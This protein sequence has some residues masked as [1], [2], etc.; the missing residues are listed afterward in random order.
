MTTRP[1]EPI[2]DALDRADAGLLARRLDAR[3]CP[4]ELLARLVR[5]PAPR[6]RH[7]GLTLLTERTDTP[8]AGD[9]SAGGYAGVGGDGEGRAGHP[10][11]LD[12]LLPASPGESPEESLL[13][14]RLHARLVTQAPR[15]RLPDWRAAALPAR[16]RIAWL[17][18]ELLDDPAVLR[19]E[20][21]GELLYRAVRESA[22]ADAR[23]PDLLVAE[24][25][26]GG[27][28]V[29]RAEA[30]RLARDGLHAGLLAPAFVRGRLVR[31]LDAPEHD[32]VTG[33]LRELAEPWAVVTP[34]DASLLS[35]PADARGGRCADG[36]GARGGSRCAE[37]G[38]PASSEALAA[39]AL[40]AG[41]RH[42]HHVVL[43]T[44]AEDPSE[45]PALRRQ[46]VELLGDQA[47]RTDIGRLV[48]LAATDPLLL[49]GPVL[50]C[51]RGLH[52]RGHFPAEPDTGPLLALALA[53]RTVPA[54]DIA[55][56]LYT[57]RR[58]LFDALVDA[59]SSAPDW[60][61]R[62]ELLVALA[63]QGAADVPIG[64]AV[65]RLLPAARA[66]RPFLDAI[67]V[68]RPQGAEEAVLALLPVAPSAALDALEAIGGD[69][70]R[71]TLARGLG[72]GGP[73]DG[74]PMA[75]DRAP[76]LP[77]APGLRPVRD[78][79]AALLWH[80][81]HEPA[82]RRDL[83]ARLDPQALPPDIEADLGA[84]DERE[85]AVLR[86][87]VDV[88]DP[89]AA[90]SRIA[91]YADAGTLPLVADLLLRIVRDLAAPRDPAHVPDRPRAD[92]LHPG[93]E[94]AEP[95]R[96][97]GEPEL[98][99]EAL[100]AVRALGRRL[101]G[102]RWIRPVCLLDA[103]DDTGAGH[104]FLTATVLG[105]LERPGLTGGERALLLKAL[106]Q[107][108]ATAS[109]R[110]RVH[111]MLRTRDP[112]VRK[113]VI[114]LLAHDSSGQDARAL[115]ATLVPLT[116]D[117]DIRTVRAALLALGTARAR[118]A[119]EAVAGCLHHPNMNIRKT[120]AATL[121]HTGAPASVPHLLR[122]LGRDDNP[123]LRSALTRALRAVVG[124]AYAATLLAAAEAA[125]DERTR[126]LLLCAL[127]GEV[128]ARAVLAL[129]VGDSPVVP[130]LLTLVADGA[131]RLAAGSV[132]DLAEPL[133][134][135]GVPTPPGVPGGPPGAADPEVAALLRTGWDPALALRIARRPVPP[136]VGIARELP[137]VRVLLGD[138]LGLAD[139]AGEAGIRGRLVRCGLRLC[140]G[141]WSADEVAVFARYAGTVTDA[142]DAA[143]GEEAGRA[144]QAGW[145]E[146]LIEVLHA[147]APHL[148]AVQR[149][150]VVEGLRR[151][152]PD[153][154][155]SPLRTGAAA[156]AFALLRRSGAVLVRADL[157][158]ALAAAHLGADPWRAGPA[159][160]REAFGVP[161]ERAAS[162]EPALWRAELAEAVRTA[163]AL[164]AFRARAATTGAGTSGA[165][166]GPGAPTVK[167]GCAPA[168]PGSREL[169][170]GLVEAYPGAAPGVRGRLV[171]WMTE[172]QPLD[173]PEWTIA[174]TRAAST[175]AGASSRPVRAD[176]LDQPRS[177]AQ[178]AR[179][180]AMLDAGQP[181]RRTTAA[182]TLSSWPEPDASLAVLR[183]YLRGRV[184][185]LPE[186]ASLDLLAHTGSH[187]EDHPEGR[188]TDH[189]EDHPAVAE[190]T[191]RGVLPER[192]LRW[193]AR[194]PED[195]LLPLVPLIVG[196]WEHGPPAVHEAARTAVRNVRADALA[197]LLTPRIEAGDLGLLDLLTGL[198]LLR[199][200]AL[201]RA[202][203]LLRTEGREALADALVLV[204]GP[205]RAPGAGS[206]DAA[207]LDALRAPAR[208]PAAPADPPTLPELLGLARTGTPEQTRRVLTRL[209]EERAPRTG[210]GPDPELRSLVEELLRHPRAG[211]RLHAHR[212][213]RA[214]FD[215]ETHARLTALLLSDPLPDVV[216]MAVR[217]LGRA[218]W[219]PA[220]PDLVRLLGHAKP[221]VRSA[222]R[223]AIV[224]FGATAVPVLRR[225][226]AHAR[227]DRRSLYTDVLAEILGPE[228]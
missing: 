188:P 116:S 39:A 92:T 131:V 87:R 13:L 25:V 17:R 197:H 170:A 7:L 93:F 165:P 54:E 136:D 132:A 86:A 28:P 198:R 222:A 44:T 4:P 48:A 190:L 110:A 72:I 147:V 175:A 62:L 138:W 30:L 80:L 122:A 100:D 23:R 46:A 224:G 89:V 205:L 55:T 49:A 10:A 150:A 83:V 172:L 31:L 200:P 67:R 186:A 9:R 140:P 85:L 180:L 113:H 191:A 94:P 213:S 21:A 120:A 125:R 126:R 228:T 102:R 76:R 42:G 168:A 91:A 217:T 34:L 182:R 207:A 71:S 139:S 192:A 40:L 195:D 220:L 129:D 8:H 204:D 36:P 22:A 61:R 154:P 115:S 58:P 43:W 142:F 166:S 137:T 16:V 149:F 117:P 77:V 169:L 121:L 45:A 151:L 162:D 225:A 194:L 211:V 11:L 167:A 155:D 82:Q 6:I 37:G 208:A 59:P 35:R 159:V 201:T 112:Q 206:E 69:R 210:A 33:A 223:D 15:H 51:L 158:R 1:D 141:P 50:T 177:A 111:R 26:A 173:A 41:A 104:A 90:L 97:D 29:L 12:R 66:P 96:P 127:D 187:T 88:D 183:A 107:V 174:E 227:P 27:D 95:P 144:G 73:M 52:R 20:P 152:P 199:T 145:A 164:A 70:T 193:A 53:D 214:L 133:A 119:G 209:V 135:H 156:S 5:H 176:D 134:R 203:R 212:T 148:S 2:S 184:D 105:L 98:P 84:P 65:A 24:L 106:L 143:T 60:P 81:T 218:S 56:V 202:E 221:V 146:E 185:V 130:A 78:R 103:Q 18:T 99:H 161:D 163:E 109:T 128:T 19:T 108:P 171:D 101:R 74:P 63:R 123:G 38:G 160:L 64:E 157:D 79:A 181:E 118:W 75:A 215:R 216:R 124:R 32:V 14:A 57:C 3:T 179:L 189:S 219:E 68:L 114:A 226:T 178:R 153:G 47:Q 196:W